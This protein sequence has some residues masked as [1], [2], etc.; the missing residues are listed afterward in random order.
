MKNFKSHFDF[1][2]KERNGI[3]FLAVIIIFLQ[4]FYFY[5]D[6]SS[7]EVVFAKEKD[8][9]RLQQKLDA[10][11]LD[12]VN[13]KADIQPF[14]PNFITDY[15]GYLLGMSVAEI[16]RL[17]AFRESGKFVNSA[18][19]FQQVTKINDSLLAVLQPYFKFPDF[20]KSQA[21]SQ[22]NFDEPTFIE[23]GDLNEIT[24]SELI[25]INGI[26]AKLAERIIAYKDLLK[27]FYF[28]DQLYE[29]YYLKK[30]VAEE[31]LKRY[32]VKT[33]PDI[34]KLNINEASFKEI[35]GLPY[36]DYSLTK[37]I[38]QHRDRFLRFE[39]LEEL[40]KIDSFPLDK[41]DRIA[42]YLEAN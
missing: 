2:K 19:E 32:T 34:E 31:V 12:S 38:F 37:R 16:D 20:V 15:K 39:N 27:G 1:N 29:V 33:K 25:E 24:V 7:D 6:F 21:K 26:G 23:K 10:A 22:T 36:I 11:Q 17:R 28:D 41:Y 14:N 5:F 18:N 35:L 3:F 42:L 8:F 9:I 30:E 4:L 13:A 40:Q